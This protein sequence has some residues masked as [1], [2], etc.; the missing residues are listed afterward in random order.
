MCCTIEVIPLSGKLKKDGITVRQEE[1]AWV[2]EITIGG[3]TFRYIGGFGSPKTAMLTG[4]TLPKLKKA[5]SEFAVTAGC[6][7]RGK[8]F[9]Y[10]TGLWGVPIAA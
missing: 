7:Y 5:F 9:R 10:G 4:N 6:M 3:K 1:G 2:H 8:C